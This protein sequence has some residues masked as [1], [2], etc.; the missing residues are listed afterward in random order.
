MTDRNNFEVIIIGG[1][2]SG[3]SAGMTL[4]RSLRNTLI[5]DSNLSCNRQTPH[6]HNF[7]TQDGK[8][9]KE[10]ASVA[11]EQVLK[12]DK[13]KFHDA[14]AISG[15]KTTDGFEITTEAGEIFTAKKLL[16][17]TGIKDIMPNIPGFADCWGISVIHCP[18]C[19]G[20]EYTGE[21]TGILAN[22]E[23]A[24]EL[25][26]L[27]SNWTSSITI[28][29]NGKSTLTQEQTAKLNKHQIEI[30]ETEIEHFEHNAGNIQNIVFK[31]SSKVEITAVYVRPTFTQH[32]DIPVQLGCELT[33]Q[34]YIKVDNM[35]KT[36]I[37]GV[38]A[39][40]DNTTAMR[41][42]ANAVATGAFAGAVINKELINEAF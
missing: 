8:T 24:F 38:F 14:L 2:Y 9:P 15:K 32:C 3:L 33:E 31:D 22:G 16:F 39:S 20:Y 25:G 19:H 11:K 36:S 28:Y 17:V 12:Y 23:T 41:S 29:T 35:Q 37:V 21:K 27:I 10:I 5:I 40:G 34:G 13:V 7:I 26:K 4:G 6:S 1:S 42:V 30:I 18:Y